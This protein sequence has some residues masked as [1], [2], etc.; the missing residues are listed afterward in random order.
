MPFK[1]IDMMLERVNRMRADSDTALFH[2]LMY[3]GEFV[4]KLTAAA[5][6]ALIDDDRERHRYRLLHS[7]IRADGLGDWSRALDDALIGPASSNLAAAAKDTDRRVFTERVGPDSWQHEAISL[8][9]NVLRQID[10]SQ[11]NTPPRVGLRMW[12]SRAADSQIESWGI[13]LRLGL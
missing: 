7:L 12:F 8:L 1:P 4:V 2:E 3:A 11:D 10:Q 9:Q 13:P 6:I 5:F